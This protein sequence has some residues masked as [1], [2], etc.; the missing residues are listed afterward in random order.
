MAREGT[1]AWYAKERAHGTNERAATS[2]VCSSQ[3]KPQLSRL[4]MCDV[5]LT[6]RD[7]SGTTLDPAATKRQL[8]RP[9]V[10]RRYS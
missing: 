5:Q 9:Q 4:L 6:L 1:V 7:V 10:A 3:E 8:H 2:D